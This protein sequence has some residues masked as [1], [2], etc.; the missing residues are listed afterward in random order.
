M[1]HG[2]HM[3]TSVVQVQRIPGVDLVNL[4]LLMHVPASVCVCVCEMNAKVQF[5]FSQASRQTNNLRIACCVFTE[6]IL[7]LTTHT[8]HSTHTTHTVHSAYKIYKSKM[9]TTSNTASQ[10]ALTI[11]SDGLLHVSDSDG[12]HSHGP[13]AVLQEQLSLQRDALLQ[14]LEMA[15]GV[16]PPQ[17]N[18]LQFESMEALISYTDQVIQVSAVLC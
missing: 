4:L 3:W 1:V 5:C 2:A 8:P 18:D 11:T 17:F 15:Q 7:H 16:P 6:Q 9:G 12:D 14:Q 13:S 10:H